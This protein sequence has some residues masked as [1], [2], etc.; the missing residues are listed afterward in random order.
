MIFLSITI[1][2]EYL[3]QLLGNHEITFFKCVIISLPEVQGNFSGWLIQVYLRF[4]H[5]L[6]QEDAGAD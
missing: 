4:I 5:I 6:K 1:D 2:Y 3:R